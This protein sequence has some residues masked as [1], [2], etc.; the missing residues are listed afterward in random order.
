MMGLFKARKEVTA[1]AK[2]NL[3]S[4]WFVAIRFTDGT[5]DY[6]QPG[7]PMPASDRVEQIMYLRSRSTGN[8]YIKYE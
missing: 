7:R 2:T 1:E 6:T 5:W 3:F 8:W 4:N